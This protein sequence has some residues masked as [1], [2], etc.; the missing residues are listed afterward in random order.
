MQLLY[1]TLILAAPYALLTLAG[2]S[3]SAL[4]FDAPTRADRFGRSARR[5][6]RSATRS[7]GTTGGTGLRARPV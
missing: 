5:T 1:L 7:G 6:I 4:R 3:V 2:W